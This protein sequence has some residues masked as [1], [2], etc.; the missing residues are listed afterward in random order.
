MSL[1][2]RKLK[3]GKTLNETGQF[4]ERQ[5]FGLAVITAS[6]GMK[7][8]T[9]KDKLLTEAQALVIRD[10]LVKNFPEKPKPAPSLIAGGAHVEIRE[11]VVPTPGSRPHDP[12]AYPDGSIWYTGHMANVLGRVDPRSGKITEYHPDIP[13][14]GPHGLPGPPSAPGAQSWT[15]R[16]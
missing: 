14:S 16:Q 9:Q 15:A 5:P 6:T 13:S 11:W 12:L 8:D 4:L 7:G 2:S 10:Y 1:L 3:S